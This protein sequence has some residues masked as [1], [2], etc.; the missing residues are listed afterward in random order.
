[1]KLTIRIKILLGFAVVLLI[2]SIVLVYDLVQMENLA[3]TT[4]DLYNHPFQVTRAVLTADADI[5]RMHR[6]MKDVALAADAA[7]INTA[8][9]SVDQSEQEVYAQLDI[10]N[11]L[12]L[13]NEGKQ[14]VTD[15]TQLIQAWKPIREEVISLSLAGKKQEAANITKTKGADQVAKISAK[16]VELKNYAAEKAEGMYTS[17]EKTKQ[18]VTLIAIAGLVFSILASISIGLFLSNHFSVPLGTLKFAAMSMARGN[19]YHDLSESQRER[20]RTQNDEIG[21]VADAVGKTRSYLTEMAEAAARIAAGDLLVTFSAKGADDELGVAFERM[22]RNLRELVGSVVKNANDLGTAAENLAS[23]ANQAGQATNQIATTIQQVATGTTQQSESVSHTAATV[24]HINQSIESVA[25][26]AQAQN[27][28]VGKTAEVTGQIFQAIEQV[29]T[30][31]QSGVDRSGQAADVAQEGAKTVAATIQGME[32]I[33]EKVSLSAGKVQEMGQRS[34]EI[35]IIVET[36][37]DIA[38]QT[39]LLALNAAI[40]AARA[41]EHGKGFAVV[42]DEVRKLAE[43]AGSATKEIGELIKVIQRTVSEAVSAMEDGSQ[44]VERGFSQ[45]RQAGDSLTS[46]LNASMEVR[47]QVTEIASSAR[48]MK[49]LS[50][51]LVTA[52]DSVRIIVEENTSATQAMNSGSVEMTR[53]IENIAS[54]SEENAASVEE[55]SASAEEMSAQVEEVTAS[56]QSL[57]EMARSLQQA[58]AQFKLSTN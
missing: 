34:E 36:I 41:G 2:S 48:S 9:S 31:A 40:E 20:V 39:N 56:A 10:A 25:R 38:S 19:L 37:E 12:I 57:A 46:I 4:A 35:G 3:K 15:A 27:K 45:A 53:A 33:R 28:A 21:E 29:A 13:G 44:E 5:I 50:S 54:V 14:L 26:G 47:Q 49:A 58:V 11:S 23:S 43:R 18:T 42:A 16:M 51:E 8:K 24:E 55:V 32:K 17:A 30:N 6:S 7:A 22:V 1:M 52:S